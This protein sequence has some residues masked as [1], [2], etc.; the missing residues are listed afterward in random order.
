M[1]NIPKIDTTNHSIVMSGTVDIFCIKGR[2]HMQDKKSITDNQKS[3][4]EDYNAQKSTKV[5]YR[6][7]PTN[8]HFKPL[9][10]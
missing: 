6:S 7:V 2:V 3:I 9:M 10:S 1:T 8:E 5:T 4:G